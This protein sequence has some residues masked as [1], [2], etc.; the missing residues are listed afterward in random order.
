MLFALLTL[1]L[2][3]GAAYASARSARLAGALRA[4]RWRLLVALPVLAAVGWWWAPDPLGPGLWWFLVAGALH[5]G[6]GDMGLFAAYRRLGPRLS[7]LIALCLTPLMSGVIEWWWLGTRPGWA[8]AFLALLVLAAVAVALAPTERLRLAPALWWSGIACA[9]AA[10]LGQALGAV[11]TRQGFALQPDAG[12]VAT[13]AWRVAGGAGVLLVVALFWR[14][15]AFARGHG[16]RLAPW[17]AVSVLLGPCLGIP[18]Y[19]QALATVPAALVQAVIA[20][21]PLTIIPLAWI[22]DGDRPSRRALLAGL[23]AVA[24]TSAMML[25]PAAA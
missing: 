15:P 11:A 2:W 18:A 22:F 23:V 8:Q 4:N 20:A 5:L 7:L 24:A 25:L 16:R 10:A 13:A 19:Q 3:T 14:E 6:L 1:F 21:L 9:V 17:L 12:A